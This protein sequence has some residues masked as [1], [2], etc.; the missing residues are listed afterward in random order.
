MGQHFRLSRC[1]RERADED[2]NLIRFL[3]HNSWRLVGLS[4][5][6]GLISGLAGAGIIALIHEGMNGSGH[7]VDL[8][9]RFF[10][11]AILVVLSKTAS[12]IL[13]TR[14]GQSTISE[15]RMQLSRLILGAPLRRIEELGHHRFMAALTDDTEVI[16]HAYTQL[17]LLCINGATVIG[18]LAYLGWLSWQVLVVVLGFMLLGSLSFQVQE[19]KAMRAFKQ[20]RETDDTL[21]QNFRSILNG[22]KELKLHRQRR[23]EFLT[24]ALQQTVSAYQRDFVK[25][26]TAYSIASSVG[27]FLFYAVIGVALFL[28]PDWQNLSVQA[29]AGV[30]LV[31]LY[32]MG[33]FS[34][35]V[36]MFPSVAR[37]DVAL[38]KIETLGLSLTPAVPAIS[39]ETAHVSVDRAPAFD[40]WKRLDLVNVTHRYYREHEERSFCLGPVD[41]TVMP[42]EIVFLIGGNG[43]GKTTLAML[44][45]GLYVPESGEIRLDGVSIDETNRDQY[46]QLF[47]AVFSDFH[48]FET[49]LGISCNRLDARAGEYLAKLQLTSKVHIERGV[50]STLALS[51]GQR[52]R[53][54]LLTA[55]LEDRPIYVF[56]EWAADQDP[57]FRK[58][59]YTEILPDLRA[60]GKAVLVITH[61]DRYFSM[62]DR[63]VRMEL[64]QI[65]DVSDRVV[66]QL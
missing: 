62:A 36:E 42:G 44:L 59:F 29:V 11:L 28:L 15:L 63:C 8:A 9:W 53:L 26:M 47:S 1:P 39:D 64:G 48:L 45:L 27:I 22:I 34:Q 7:P 49:M 57:V 58:V 33:P 23:Q 13:L 21:F 56:D 2:M 61:D 43:S 54:A 60:R 25:G 38:Q 16:A 66:A 4:V 18:C 52:K 35:I 46:R 20:A 37:A 51:Q 12:E 24:T 6:A 41:L 40:A 32:M 19:R 65:E 17:P 5:L 14:L 31:L 10:F 30:T 3:L 50:L 55:Y